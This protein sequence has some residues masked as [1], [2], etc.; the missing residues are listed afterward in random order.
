MGGVAA[1]LVFKN[2]EEDIKSVITDLWSIKLLDIDEQ[3][4]SLKDFA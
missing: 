1:K 3:E 4:V 2:K